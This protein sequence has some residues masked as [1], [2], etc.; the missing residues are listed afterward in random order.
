MIRNNV[1]Q[2]IQP[3]QGHRG[4]HPALVGDR[5]RQ[6]VVE[7]R[8]PVGG[9]DHQVFA[10]RIDVT[11][12]AARAQF[13][14]GQIGFKDRSQSLLVSRPTG[15]FSIRSDS[16]FILVS[17]STLPVCDRTR[18]IRCLTR[19]RLASIVLS[20]LSEGEINPYELGQN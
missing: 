15:N 13:H 2:L 16:D 19:Y 9:D 12:L 17:F 7:S 1:P 10:G 14:A 20:S 11:Y 6:N 8:Q 4:E 3:E 18:L 5:R